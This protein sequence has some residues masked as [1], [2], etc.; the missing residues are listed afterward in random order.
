MSE[1]SKMESIAFSVRS[2]DAEHDIWVVPLRPALVLEAENAALKSKRDRSRRF[3]VTL[4]KERWRL[5]REIAVLEREKV[6]GQ[7]GLLELAWGLIANA[8][9]WSVDDDDMTPCGERARTWVRSAV[10]WREQYHALLES[11]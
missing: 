11:E 6:E 9:E 4:I 5:Y 10:N 7:N 1:H 8:D 2:P 3:C